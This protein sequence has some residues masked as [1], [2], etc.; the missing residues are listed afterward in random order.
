MSENRRLFKG[1]IGQKWNFESKNVL[2]VVWVGI[3][4]L[5]LLFYGENYIFNGELFVVDNKGRYRNIYFSP[6]QKLITFDYCNKEGCNN[7]IHEVESGLFFRYAHDEGVNITNLSFSPS[8]EQIV[9]VARKNGWFGYGEEMCL[10]TGA[11]GSSQF[12]VV[13][14]CEAIKAYPKF[15]SE[16]HILFWRGKD[17][18]NKK[19]QIV[20]AEINKEN[21]QEKSIDIENIDYLYRPS[22]LSFFENKDEAVFSDYGISEKNDGNEKKEYFDTVWILSREEKRAFPVETGINYSSKPVVIKSDG[23]ILFI[24]R[25]LAGEKNGVFAYEIYSHKEGSTKQLTNFGSYISGFDTT[26]DGNK[27]VLAIEDLSDGKS[28]LVVLNL[29]SKEVQR[30]VPNDISKL[31]ITIHQ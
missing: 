2:A 22:A 15:S 29:K 16:N 19:S 4:G 21:G 20:L 6:D 7:V 25:N 12:R 1:S 27:L 17:R 10:V 11:H 18:A 8:G 9:F 3:L 28:S 13:G 24:G 30:I 23:R 26:R 31:L 14:E 5:V